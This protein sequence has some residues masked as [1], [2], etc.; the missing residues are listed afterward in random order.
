MDPFARD[1]E[2]VRAEFDLGGAFLSADVEKRFRC[3]KGLGEDLE[4]HRGFPDARFPAEEDDASVN[5][6]PS[7][8]AIELVAVRPTTLAIVCR[9]VGE[10]DR[11][12]LFDSGDRCA[13]GG[14]RRRRFGFFP[15][16]VPCLAVGTLAAPAC[17]GRIAGLATVQR[18]GFHKEGQ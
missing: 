11:S 3:P 12:G 18:G 10:E 9:H 17:A 5:D 15:Q 4:Q 6:P 13:A 14:V 7:E 1:A 8:H 16:C 2:T